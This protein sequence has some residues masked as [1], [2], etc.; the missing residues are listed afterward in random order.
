MTDSKTASTHKVGECKWF[1]S[2][3]GFGFITPKDG[4]E[5][6][7][8]HQ[9][10]IHA[11]GFRSLAEKEPV[12]FDT[13]ID[14]NGRIK[15]L[16]VTGPAG[17]YVKGAPKPRPRFNDRRRGGDENGDHSGAPRGGRGG[18]RGG[19]GRGGARAP[20]EAQSEAQ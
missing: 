18:G 5:D 16:N 14:E 15:A 12:E 17:A 11:E 1:N 2:K 7:F 10:A 3:K 9:S 4:S 19:R 6:V 20:R 8:V 13:A